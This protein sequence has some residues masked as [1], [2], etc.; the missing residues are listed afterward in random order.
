MDAHFAHFRVGFD[1]E[2]GIPVLQKKAGKHACPGSDVSDDVT[3]LQSA[4]GAKKVKNFGRISRA[5]ADVILHPIGK[6]SRWRL[7]HRSLV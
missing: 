1:G 6:A 7:T 2:N 4:F 3:R 5:I